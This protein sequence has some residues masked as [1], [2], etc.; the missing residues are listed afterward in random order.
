MRSKTTI[1]AVLVAFTLTVAG[2]AQ[3]QDGYIGLSFGDFTK[4]DPENGQF[5][6]RSSMI[7]GLYH[8]QI[9]AGALVIEGSRQSDNINSAAL[10]GSEM[11]TQTHIAVHYIHT[12]G[13]AATVSGFLGYG[14]TPHASAR[15]DISVAY[16]GI[17][18]SYAISPTVTAYGQLGLGDAPRE[19]TAISLGGSSG[20]ADAEFVRLGV[21]YTGL[22]RTT[23]SFE[24]E[25]AFSDRYEDTTEPGS[26][27]SVY[28]GGSTSLTTNQDFQV[29]YGARSAFFDAQGGDFNRA[30][31]VTA[32]LGMR[33]VFGGTGTTG[34]FVRK[35]VLGSPYLPL[36]ATNWTPALD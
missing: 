6:G 3:A 33:Y 18:G 1:G 13:S 24:Y 19:E 35:G 5:H 9:G 17:G 34:D 29:T 28:L 12:I 16:G 20:F 23:L 8:M 15:H 21:T 10:W 11:T 26:F 32:S 2:F 14:V 36:R 27:G 31:E 22:Q 30:E 7:E 4:D 25:R